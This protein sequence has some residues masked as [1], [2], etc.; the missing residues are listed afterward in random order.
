LFNAEITVNSY[1]FFHH[2]TE[3]Q[4]T[5]TKEHLAVT[6]LQLYKIV[7]KSIV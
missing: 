2:W 1:S 6:R 7:E 3:V 4:E 5:L